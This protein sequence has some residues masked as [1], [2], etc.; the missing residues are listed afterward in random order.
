[1]RVVS[2]LVA[3]ALAALPASAFH[4]QIGCSFKDATVE[5]ALARGT[6]VT[7]YGG[8]VRTS[9]FF[10]GFV[11]LG[12]TPDY[13]GTSS[14]KTDAK[15]RV[16]SFVKSVNIYYDGSYGNF[17]SPSPSLH[18]HDPDLPTSVVIST[19]ALGNT[20]FTTEHGYWPVEL[21]EVVEV[22]DVPGYK[23]SDE[24]KLTVLTVRGDPYSTVMN[25]TGENRTINGTTIAAGHSASLKFPIY[26]KTP[27]ISGARFY[28]LD[29][30]AELETPSYADGAYALGYTGNIRISTAT[31]MPTNA[32]NEPLVYGDMADA[33][34]DRLMFAADGAPIYS[35]VV[36]VSTNIAL[37]TWWD[38]GMG[39]WGSGPKAI[40]NGEVV[41]GGHA[42]SHMI[43]YAVN[44]GSLKINGLLGYATVYFTMSQ[45]PSSGYSGGACTMRCWDANMEYGADGY[46]AA[47]AGHKAE[48][49][50]GTG[51]ARF[52]LTIY[53]TGEWKV[54][55]A[56]D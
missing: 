4:V 56:A 20:D 35:S 8:K 9:P 53:T 49:S 25:D 31:L 27:E 37:V 36:E 55:P 21:A 54:E 10:G 23:G 15:L 52:K 41:C 18:W 2:T 28:D 19:Y 33:N 44:G 7:D 50:A 17:Y 5:S 38:F 39:E 22:G 43:P 29:S 6:K 46:A 40:I 3:A 11:E 30:G 32:P 26:L 47:P 42:T 34:A 14:G 1:M 45:T 51:T 48:I 16:S 13:L 12:A 24:A